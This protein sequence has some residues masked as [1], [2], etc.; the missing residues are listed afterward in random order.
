MSR[1]AEQDYVLGTNDEELSRLGLQHSVWRPTAL[2][3]W[4]RAGIT[5]GARVLDVGAGPGFAT[6]DLAEMVGP[7]GEVVA[8]ERSGRFVQAGRA[9]CKGRGMTHVRFHE[10][11]LMT[12]AL[13]VTGFDVAWIRWVASFVSSPAM[14]VSKIAAA[15]RPGGA[16]AFHE[17]A[18]YATWRISPRSRLFEDFVQ[19]VMESWRATGGEPDIALAL[20]ALLVERG[21]H[22]R[23]S[24]PCVFCVRPQDHA[25]HWPAAFLDINLNRLLELRRVDEAWATAVRDAFAEAESNPHTLMITP[26][27][28]EII[29]ERR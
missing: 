24:T 25:W 18:D 20:P 17:Y 15:I 5:V 11:D 28:L 29:A 14:L 2:A 1:H 3:C 23:S 19:Q 7:T 21:F 26:M 4:Q 13:P 22:I 16:A 27:V 8:V 12:E 6:L 10:L 9:A